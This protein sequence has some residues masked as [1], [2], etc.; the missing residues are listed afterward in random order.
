MPL[1][2]CHSAPVKN[3]LARREILLEE[4]GDSGSTPT[5]S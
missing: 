4:T 3:Y 5:P 1:I 2:P